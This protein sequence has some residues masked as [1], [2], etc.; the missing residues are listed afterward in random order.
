MIRLVSSWDIVVNEFINITIH[1]FWSDVFNFFGFL[2]QCFEWFWIWSI[3]SW[4]NRRMIG[5]ISSWD[6]VVNEFVYISVHF[7][8]SDVFNFFGFLSQCFEWFWI[9]S[10]RSW[11]NRWMFNLISSW[12]IVINKSIDIFIHF[13]RSNILLFSQSFMCFWVWSVWK[14]WNIAL[15]SWKRFN[16]TCYESM[17]FCINSFFSNVWFFFIFFFL[18]KSFECFGIGSIW[19]IWDLALFCWKWFYNAC[20]KSMN[21]FIYSFFANVWFFFILFILS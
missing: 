12:D 20:Y 15:F 8:W 3:W 13:S 4:W 5:L 19:K 10:I 11:W 7:F 16:Y 14:I 1:F 6:I 9:W 21:F 18:S 2:S 17:Y